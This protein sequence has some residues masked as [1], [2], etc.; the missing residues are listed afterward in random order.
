MGRVLLSGRG[1]DSSRLFLVISV[2]ELVVDVV[3]VVV[4]VVVAVCRASAVVI[5]SDVAIEA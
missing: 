2:P 4:V 3:V 1:D 5:I